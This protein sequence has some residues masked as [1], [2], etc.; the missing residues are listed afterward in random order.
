MGVRT[1][2]GGAWEEIF[3]SQAPTCGGHENSGSGPGA[4]GT[5]GGS[6]MH[7]WQPCWSVLCFRQVG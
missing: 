7:M 3:N 2:V 6:W 1:G 4:R 5:D